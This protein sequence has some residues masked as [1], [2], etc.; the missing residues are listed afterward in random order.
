MLT[1]RKSL[2]LIG[3]AAVLPAFRA[4]AAEK[5]VRI[6]AAVSLTGQL[7]HE[8]NRLKKGYVYWEKVVSDAGGIEVGGHKLPVRVFYYDDESNAQTSARLTE[9]CIT[10]DKVGAMFGPYSSG[11]ATATA[12]ISEKYRIPT[13]AAMATA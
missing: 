8:G 10:E 2:G 3:A 13:I 11:I 1:R 12:A 6:G 4:A 5:M 7:S 9:R